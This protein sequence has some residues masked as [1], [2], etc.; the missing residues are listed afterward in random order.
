MFNPLLPAGVDNAYHGHKLALVLFGVLFA[1]R[2][3]MTSS[4]SA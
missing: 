4:S 3:T 1:M 2:T